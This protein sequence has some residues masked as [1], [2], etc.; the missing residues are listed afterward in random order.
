MEN[1]PYITWK[2]FFNVILALII[3]TGT[4]ICGAIAWGWS[5]YQA[6]ITIL[7]SETR[8]HIHDVEI[9]LN[10]QVQRIEDKLDSVLDYLIK[11]DNE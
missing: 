4:P 10:H 2:A 9:R 3:T 1:N 7:K 8:N 5:D 11:N 6:K